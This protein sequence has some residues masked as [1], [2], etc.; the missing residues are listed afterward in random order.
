MSLLQAVHASFPVATLEHYS[1]AQLRHDE[2]SNVDICG[3]FTSGATLSTTFSLAQEAF[4]QVVQHGSAL[5]TLDANAINFSDDDIAR[6]DEIEIDCLVKLQVPAGS[7]WTR[8]PATASGIF[9]I[10]PTG[11]E[12]L[13]P[14]IGPADTGA[15]RV[16]ATGAA[17]V[18]GQRCTS[19]CFVDDKPTTNAALHYSPGATHYVIGESFGPMNPGKPDASTALQKLLRIERILC[20]IQAKEGMAEAADICSCVLGVVLIGP[21]M[22]NT[23]CAAVF[24]AIS[25][26][27]SA[28]QRLWALYEAKR[29]LAIHLP[30]LVTELLQGLHDCRANF[31]LDAAEDAADR[32]KIDALSRQVAEIHAEMAVIRTKQAERDAKVDAKATATYDLIATLIAKVDALS[33][34]TGDLPALHAAGGA[35][36]DG[37]GGLYRGGGGGNLRGGGRGHGRGRGRGGAQHGAGGPLGGL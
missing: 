36:A 15:C 2:S 27:K 35:T 11:Q 26:Y 20:V 8:D 13:T 22:D 18:Y 4:C 1:G 23:T 17:V 3:I 30:P 10:R 6:N 33:A 31:A 14:A 32:A 25:G 9:H 5:P 12:L 28:L 19:A 7:I 21:S 16:P 24:T 34:N 37:D 29:L